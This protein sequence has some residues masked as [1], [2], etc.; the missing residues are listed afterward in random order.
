MM[1]E[2]LDDRL[3]YS[4]NGHTYVMR[5]APARLAMRCGLRVAGVLSPV[6]RGLMSLKNAEGA[7]AAA[8]A[9]LFENPELEDKVLSLVDAFAPY[10]EVIVDGSMPPQSYNLGSKGTRGEWIDVHFAGKQDQM[11]DWLGRACEQNLSSFLGGLLAKAKEA[12]SALAGLG[13]TPK[14]TPSQSPDPA[15]TTG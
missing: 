8:M 12:E 7:F 10:T 11:I 15:Q 14:K 6:M 13:V 3:T 9:Y 1:N 2:Q 4:S 5:K